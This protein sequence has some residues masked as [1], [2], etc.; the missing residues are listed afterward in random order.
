M[1]DD[2]C[3]LL[4]FLEP[5]WSLGNAFFILLSNIH[6]HKIECQITCLEINK[7]AFTKIDF[8]LR[9]ARAI[10]IFC[11]LQI[12]VIRSICCK[13]KSWM[14]AGT[15]YVWKWQQQ[16]KPCNKGALRVLGTLW[17]RISPH[18]CFNRKV[19]TLTKGNVRLFYIL[20]SKVHWMH[21]MA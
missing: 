15:D 17:K 12:C 6:S 10:C 19:W 20:L 7:M 13:C 11:E 9:G 14:L 16:Q 5:S 18:F 1:N 4:D 8:I 21:F 2:W 3:R